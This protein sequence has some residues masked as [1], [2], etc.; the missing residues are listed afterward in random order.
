MDE[1]FL[2]ESFQSIQAVLVGSNEN[3]NGLLGRL[4]IV[5]LV[6][7]DELE[8]LHEGRQVYILHRDDRLLG[9][10]HPHREHVLEE[11]GP[12]C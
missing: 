1:E 7:V 6:R 3:V 8:K 9:L 4:Q 5:Q 12:R 10:A 11:A 2:A